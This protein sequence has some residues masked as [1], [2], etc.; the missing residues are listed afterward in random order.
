M[1]RIKEL[2]CLF[3]HKSCDCK[4]GL[5]ESVRNS[6]HKWNNDGCWCECKTLDHWSF[7]KKDCV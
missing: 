3:Q 2:R 7:C 4:S 6:K 1:Q 5:N